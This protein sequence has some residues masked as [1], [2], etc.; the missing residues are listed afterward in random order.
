MFKKAEGHKVIRLW[1]Q[2]VLSKKKKSRTRREK[3][4]K[5]SRREWSKVYIFAKKKWTRPRKMWNVCG[6]VWGFIWSLWA[7]FWILPTLRR[8]STEEPQKKRSVKLKS[9][10]KSF[11][12]CCKQH[13]MVTYC[14]MWQCLCFGKLHS[15]SSSELES[16]ERDTRRNSQLEITWEPFVNNLEALFCAQVWH[17]SNNYH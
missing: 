12:W 5:G 13:R 11:E 16:L 2:V 7:I 8:D 4:K 14:A 1:L 6:N 10:Q 3:D 15:F 9:H 17:R